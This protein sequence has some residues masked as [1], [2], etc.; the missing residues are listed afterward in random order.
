VKLLTRLSTAEIVFWDFDGVIKDSVAVKTEAFGR[1]FSCY[2][3]S[4]VKNVRTHHEANGGVSRYE[5]IPFYFEQ[6]VGIKLSEDA[7]DR[8]CDE[9]GQMVIEAVI[10]SPWVGGVESYLHRN[11]NNQQFV[12]VTGTPKQEIEYI[13]GRLGLVSIFTA[14]FG[15]PASKKASVRSVLDDSTV[16]PSRTVFLGDALADVKAA[17]ANLVP[18]FLRETL[19]NK[20]WVSEMGLN[21]YHDLLEGE[22]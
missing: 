8:K 13:L 1:M 4:V 6:F 22:S 3:D 12:L 19:L 14:V 9:F 20:K 10:E 18:F 16:D 21:T 17:R 7:I 11:P 5:K 15:A 2:G